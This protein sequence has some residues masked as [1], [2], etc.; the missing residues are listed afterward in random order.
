[1]ANSRFGL[2]TPKFAN[3]L[4]YKMSYITKRN[5]YFYYVRRVPEI[6]SDIDSRKFVRVSL[7]TGCKAEAKRKAAQVDDSVS[8]YWAE[9]RA[10]NAVHENP[11]FRKVVRAARQY[12]F[13]YIPMDSVL[14]LPAEELV[15]RIAAVDEQSTLHVEALLGGKE[16]ER[17]TLSGA[18]D[19]FW[20]LAESQVFNK[21]PDMLRKWK[22]PRRRA[23]QNLIKIRGNKQLLS[24]NR[25][26]AL[27]FQK[28]WL[29]R[30][31]VENLSINAAN[32][33]LIHARSVL[34]KVA[35]HEKLEVDID[36]VFKGLLIGERFVATR[37]PFSTEQIK[38][39]IA[40]AEKSNLNDDAKYCLLALAETGARPKEIWGLEPRDI[41]L[42]DPVPHIKIVDRLHRPLKTAHSQ[43]DIPIVGHALQAYL[44]MPNG[45]A[46]YRDKPDS[47][48]NL[49]NKFLKQ[50]KLLPSSEHS[51]YSLRHSFQDRLTDANAPER[52]QCELM[53]HKFHRP[54]YG[55]GASLPQKLDWME[56]VKV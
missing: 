42:D 15:K 38:A 35:E 40:A 50:S 6:F 43:R 17:L 30:I 3:I 13:S 45:I 33:D 2:L 10:K 1:M 22:N 25:E 16:P 52:I 29:E 21:T 39:I 37:K 46:R 18:L 23:I 47:L 41:V 24:L 36:K 19:K 53:G 4:G 8:N 9:L 14:R 28:H 34:K 56:K 5:G 31:K 11:R 26:D 44:A 54:K 32:K 51:V 49:L 48:T 7:K 20:A 55:I 27:A 12:G